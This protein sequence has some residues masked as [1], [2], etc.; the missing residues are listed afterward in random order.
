MLRRYQ[1]ID[2]NDL[3]RGAERAQAYSGDARECDPRSVHK[4]SAFESAS[5]LKEDLCFG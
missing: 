3:R 5:L 2:L 1:I 4:H